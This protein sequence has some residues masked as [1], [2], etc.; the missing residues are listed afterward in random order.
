MKI[1]GKSDGREW[2]TYVIIL[3]TVR[4]FIFCLHVFEGL[5]PE[6]SD[7]SRN[8]HHRTRGP[9]RKTES[10]VCKDILEGLKQPGQRLPVTHSYLTRHGAYAGIAHVA[11]H[12]PECARFNSRIGVDTKYQFSFCVPQAVVV[13]APLTLIGLGEHSYITH[14]MLR[15][16]PTGEGKR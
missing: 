8:N 12:Q 2:S 15:V 11:L 9:L 4:L 14:S 13:S 3:T 6:E 16:M 5:T 1:L 7:R 10:A